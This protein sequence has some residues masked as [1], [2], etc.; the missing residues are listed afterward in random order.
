MITYDLSGPEPIERSNFEFDGLIEDSAIYENYIVLMDFMDEISF[1]DISNPDAPA[2]AHIFDP[3]YSNSG[4]FALQGNYM[5][6]GDNDFVIYDLS[7]PLQP[8]LVS[9][10][11]LSFK[12]GTLVLGSRVVRYRLGEMEILD[13]SNLSEPTVID[14]GTLDSFT[15]Q[16]TIF[17]NHLYT[18]S[19]EKG[20]SIHDLN[21]AGAPEIGGTHAS[22]IPITMATCTTRTRRLE[23]LGKYLSSPV[24]WRATRSMTYNFGPNRVCSS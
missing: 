11:P 2:V 17:E 9:S 21:A 16:A 10:T 15:I 20:L 3:G 19:K 5:Y 4:K 7:N 8:Q 6:F 23:K 14:S 24:L 1:L 22:M 18:V 13:V 12:S